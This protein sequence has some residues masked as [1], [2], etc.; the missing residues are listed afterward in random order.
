MRLTY[1]LLAEAVREEL[2]REPSKQTME[3]LIN[4][5]G[6]RWVSIHRWAYLRQAKID[7]KLVSGTERYRLPGGVREV[8][9]ELFRPNS[10]WRPI[11]VVSFD[12]FT[13]FRERYLAGIERPYEP[14][15]TTVREVQEGDDRPELYL[16]VFPSSITETVVTQVELGWFPVNAKSDE[17][18]LPDH[19]GVYFLEF[20]RVY[21][22]HREFPE[23]SRY[24]AYMAGL[25]FREAKRHDARGSGQIQYRGGRASDRYHS[26]RHSVRRARY[27]ALRHIHERGFMRGNSSRIGP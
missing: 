10:I 14:L 4:E 26:Q 15:A 1:P 8:G 21:A 6:E 12:A 23:Q 22:M 24:E 20:L 17:V 9:D 18:Y 13:A 3:S 25:D 2:A 7:I 27:D 19:L 11:P 5:A 16:Y